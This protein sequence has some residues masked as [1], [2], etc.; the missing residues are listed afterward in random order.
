MT[1]GI[2]LAA[3]GF[4]ALSDPA[5]FTSMS[6]SSSDPS[7]VAS[8]TGGANDVTP[9][10][11]SVSVSQIAQS[12]RTISNGAASSGSALGLSGTLRISLGASSAS[13]DVSPTDSL[14]DVAGA[15]AA[16]GLRAQAS[17]VYDGSQY[18]LL[19][20][21][22][23]TGAA[24]AVT[25]DE[26]GL[27]GSGYSLGLSNAGSTLQQ[28]QDAQLT[29][30][31]IAVTSPTNEITGAIPGVTLAVTQPTG[32]TATVSI[33]SDASSVAQKI[34]AFV[35]AYNTVVQDG[36]T[37]SGFGTQAASNALLQG[38]Q[39][40]RG[41]LDEL[42]SLMSETVPGASGQYSTLASVGVTLNDDVG[43][44]KNTVV[45]CPRS[46]SA[47]DLAAVRLDDLLRDIRARDGS[48]VSARAPRHGP[49]RGSARAV[50]RS[51]ARRVHGRP[52]RRGGAGDLRRRLGVRFERGPLLVRHRAATVTAGPVR[53]RRRRDCACRVAPPGVEPG[54]PFGPRILNP[55]RLP[56]PPRGPTFPVAIR[57]VIA[58]ASERSSGTASTGGTRRRRHAAGRSRCHDDANTGFD[59]PSR[60]YE[61]EGTT[62]D[63]HASIASL[64]GALF[65]LNA[66]EH[67]SVSAPG[68]LKSVTTRS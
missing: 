11:W 14:S 12:Q 37:D 7:V 18:R 67:L 61:P 32:S 55:L 8:V 22:L 47:P 5:G 28:A 23:D 33:A 1:T 21:G 63:L 29:V 10:Q 4:G 54:R 45:P 36:H 50:L 39:A 19:V 48:C 35:S 20:A 58:S 51:G 62:I 27:S 15:I 3:F 49:R 13:V 44:V 59:R 17:V 56:I 42:G 41:S 52:V 34:Q 24:N 31:G 68:P 38:D 66:N 25:F 65:G 53:R 9:G 16:S 46:L 40:I 60:S 57:V 64:G 2:D 26:S 6:A 30:G 43:M